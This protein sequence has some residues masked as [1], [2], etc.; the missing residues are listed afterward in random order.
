MLENSQVEVIDYFSSQSSTQYCKRECQAFCTFT[1]ILREYLK[2]LQ[3]S[4]VAM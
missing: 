2:I 1:L 3:I 4:N